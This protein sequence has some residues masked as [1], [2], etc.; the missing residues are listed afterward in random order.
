MKQ[1]IRGIE[2]ARSWCSLLI[3]I[4]EMQPGAEFIVSVTEYKRIRTLAQN[5]KMHAMIR[6]VSLQVP[7]DG[8]M[9]SE[10]DWKTLF[11]AAYAQMELVPGLEGGLVA[12][13]VETHDMDKA[14][15]SDIIELIY[16]FGEQHDVVWS[17]QSRIESGQREAS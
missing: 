7:W 12:L 16:A 5:S 15:L 9:R 6:D 14:E 8:Q 10:S 17:E 3:R 2:Q 4:F 11:T 13:P 1:V